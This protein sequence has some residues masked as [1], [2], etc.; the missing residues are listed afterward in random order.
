M[1]F[2]FPVFRCSNSQAHSNAARLLMQTLLA[3][4]WSFI[5]TQFQIQFKVHKPSGYRAVTKDRPNTHCPRPT[6]HISQSTIHHPP[7]TFWLPFR[8]VNNI[9]I[10]YINIYIYSWFI[11]LDQHKYRANFLSTRNKTLNKNSTPRSSNKPVQDV[12]IETG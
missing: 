6:F 11:L 4:C 7:S 1:A 12:G 9:A 2:A 5:I 3:N 8:K 10:L